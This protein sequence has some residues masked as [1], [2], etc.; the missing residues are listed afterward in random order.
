MLTQLTNYGANLM[1]TATAPIVLDS[2]QLGSSAGYVPTVSQA[3][4]HGTLIYTGFPAAPVVE[5]AN[6]VKYSVELGQSIGPFPFGEIALF[7]QGN[8]FAICVLDT[9]INKLPLDPNDDTGGAVIIDIYVPMVGS[10]YEMW[11]NVAQAN[12]LRVSVVEGPE[13]LPASTNAAPNLYVVQA[14]PSGNGFLAYTD[15]VGI[16]NFESYAPVVTTQ[17]LA[18]TASTITVATPAVS[19]YAVSSVGQC[20]V[21]LVTGR[22]F[23]TCRYVVAE[24]GTVHNTTVLSLNA[25]FAALP[26]PGD[27]L[28]VSM[29]AGLL[30]GPATAMRLGMVKPGTSMTILPDGTLNVSQANVVTDI[31]GNVLGALVAPQ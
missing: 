28:Q 30:L 14:P 12:T 16:W 2:F 13:A 6:N 4:I 25:P 17:V 24:V 23:G 18:A 5:D 31:N 8:L 7:Y 20:I 22:L 29:S 21:Q 15:R 10:N 27:M 26:L 9:V 19:G 1:A 3:A 11:A